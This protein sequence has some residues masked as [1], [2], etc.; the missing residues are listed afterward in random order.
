MTEP[1]VV[2]NHFAH[3]VVQTHP[4]GKSRTKQSMRDQVNANFIVRRWEQSGV[5][6][7]LN[8]GIPAYGDFTNVDDYR[9]SLEKIRGAQSDFAELPAAVRDRCANDPTVF[10]AWIQN[11]EMAAELRESGLGAIAD[12]LH[13]PEAPKVAA[14]DSPVVEP[15]APGVPPAPA[16][17]PAS[18]V[19]GGD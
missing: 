6:E 14:P 3:P 12:K 9:S 5:V 17:P 11:P 8:K 7:H 18:P 13:G 1:F 2:R 15:S 16:A 10:L 4:V 19:A